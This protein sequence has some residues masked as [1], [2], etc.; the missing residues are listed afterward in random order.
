MLS[1]GANAHAMIDRLFL[2]P[3][4]CNRCDSQTVIELIGAAA[5]FLFVLSRSGKLRI[6]QL[7]EQE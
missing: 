1:A 6:T 4:I 7:P 3:F 5:F 2:P